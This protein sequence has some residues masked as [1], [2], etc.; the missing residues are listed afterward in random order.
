MSE[1]SLPRIRKRPKA[2]FLTEEVSGIPITEIFTSF[3]HESRAGDKIKCLQS[4]ERDHKG[5]SGDYGK[6]KK[7]PGH[8][9]RNPP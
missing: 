5:L 1:M 2:I 6:L 7:N 3:I 9:L 4:P 8:A